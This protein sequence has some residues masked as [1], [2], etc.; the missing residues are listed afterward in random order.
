MRGRL[1][2]QCQAVASG[3]DALGSPAVAICVLTRSRCLADW[4]PALGRLALDAAG[5]PFRQRSPP[6]L[7]QNHPPKPERARKVGPR[8][9][10]SPIR[11]P[12]PAKLLLSPGRRGC[13][14]NSLSAGSAKAII[15]AGRRSAPRY[16][17]FLGAYRPPLRCLWR[18]PCPVYYPRNPDPLPVGTPARGHDRCTPATIGC[19][20]QIHRSCGETN[21]RCWP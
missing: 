12:S 14:G 19:Q 15:R 21:N 2:K 5:Q 7:F 1:G 17:D 9:W 3:T 11:Q 18:W 16:R 8:R 10:P 13:P 20:R 4:L 6:G